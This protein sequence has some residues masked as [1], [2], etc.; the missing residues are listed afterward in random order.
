MIYQHRL[1]RQEHG[2]ERRGHGKRRFIGNHKPSVLLYVAG[3]A[4]DM[5]AKMPDVRESMEPTDEHMGDLSGVSPQAE[6][7]AGGAHDDQE[8]L[9]VRLTS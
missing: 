8:Q 2:G 3:M 4:A 7:Q 9:K 1:P 5:H 6:R